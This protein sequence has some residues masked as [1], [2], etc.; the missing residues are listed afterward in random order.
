MKVSII[1][2]VYNVADYIECCLE[3]IRRQTYTDI[4]V[5]LVD[6]CGSDNSIDLAHNFIEVHKLQNYRIIKHLHNRGLSASRNTG[7]INAAGDYVYFLDS[8]DYIT[9]GCIEKLVEPLKHFHYSFV[10]AGYRVFPDDEQIQ[11]CDGR[12]CEIL[13]NDNVLDSYVRG[14]WYMMAWNKLCNRDFLLKNALFFEEGLLHEDLAWSFKLACKTESMCC[15][16]D[17]TYSYRIRKNSI[18]TSM[19]IEGDVL[20]YLNVFDV[21]SNYIRSEGRVESKNDY[22]YFQGKRAGIMYSLLNKNEYQLFRKY[23]SHFRSQN[24]IGP[25]QAYRLGI[26]SLPYML[27]DLHYDLPLWM[28]RLYVIFFYNA[29]YRLRNKNIEGALWQ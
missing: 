18:M 27:R 4:E 3:S 12:L 20:A 5:I 7:L 6:D 21:L 15:V 14:Q 10:L 13:G 23:Y 29:F 26:M 2:P 9:L 16:P 25:I 17:I 19:T 22:K 8:D 11:L 1:V 28:G 24:Y